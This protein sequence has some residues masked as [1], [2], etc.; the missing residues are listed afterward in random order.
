MSIYSN[1]EIIHKVEISL[2]ILLT[3]DS[4]L[5]QK[6]GSERSV[7]HKLAE[8][9]QLLFL[10]WNVD[11]EY[12][13]KN[14]DIKVLD[15]IRECSE[16]RTTDRVSPDIII[17]RRNTNENLLVIE[18]KIAKDDLCDIEKLKKFTFSKG[19]YRYQL[20]LFIKFN[21]TE[22]PSCNWFNN[23]DNFRL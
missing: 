16:Q 22:E 17:H 21:L 12:N 19:E 18:I 23:G 4:F 15:G 7:A 10:D 9:L 2:E 5:L 1:A 3:N 11:C 14:L 8:Y 20:G 13:R 6:V